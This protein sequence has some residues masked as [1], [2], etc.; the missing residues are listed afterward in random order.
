M[1]MNKHTV[2][3]INLLSNCEKFSEEFTE[4]I[5]FL[6]LNLFS[7]YDQIELHLNS[8]DM[9]AF[10][11]SLELLCQ[12]TLSMR[13]TNLSAQFSWEII[14]MLNFNILHDIEVFIDNIEIKELKMKY[15]NEKSLSEICHFILEHL[16]M[17]DCIF[18]TLKLINIKIFRK[19][20]YFD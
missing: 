18:L 14:Q 7:D 10:M 12:I 2:R 15:N 17:L 13:T 11:M 9:I 8:C 5:I 3:N 19:K 20:L 6:L 16:Q 4:M 1:H